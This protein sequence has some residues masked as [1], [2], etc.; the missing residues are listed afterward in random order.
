MLLFYQ[1]SSFICFTIDKLLKTKDYVP[2]LNI[3]QNDF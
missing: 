1:V 2:H 3:R